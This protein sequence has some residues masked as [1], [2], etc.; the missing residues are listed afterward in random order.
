MR[1]HTRVAGQPKRRA[2]THGDAAFTKT[3]GD[4]G[5]RVNGRRLRHGHGKVVSVSQLRTESQRRQLRRQLRGAVEQLGA[6]LGER[7]LTLW[8]NLEHCLRVT[9]EDPVRTLRLHAGTQFGVHQGIS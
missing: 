6:A 1:N 7:K 2:I 8:V 3:T 9:T 5:S 4:I